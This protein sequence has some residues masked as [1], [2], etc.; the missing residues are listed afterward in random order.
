MAVGATS[1]GGILVV[2]SLTAVAGI[3]VREAIAASNFC[4]LFTGAATVYLQRAAPPAVRADSA[5]DRGEVYL[6][7]L[8]GAAM[9]SLT[10]EWLPAVVV[11]AMVAVV[12]VLSGTMALVGV[13]AT[14]A[15]ELGP[16]AL[17][18]IGLGVGCASA[19]SG[20]GGPV[21]LLPILIFARMPLLPAVAMAQIIQ[22]PIAAA[23]TAVNFIAGRLDLGLGLAL[24]M[25]VLAGWWAGWW[26]AQRMS[27]RAL[28]R[29]VALGLIAVGLAYGWQTL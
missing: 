13:R 20:T 7:A 14:P 5:S 24:A 19:W 9:G 6:A 1:I 8:L 12:A 21:L 28:Q 29:A 23:A 22:L 27:V 2:P 25:L 26:L 11:H 3:P 17:A 15:K 4:F 18:W 16:T 10:L